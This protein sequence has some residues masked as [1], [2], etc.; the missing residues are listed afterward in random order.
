MWG[1]QVC[2]NGRCVG[3]AGVWD[4]RCVGIAGVCGMTGVWGWQVCGDGR[5]VEIA[6][7]WF[8]RIMGMGRILGVIFLSFPK[9]LYNRN[10]SVYVCAYT[11]G[12]I[13]MRL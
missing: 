8:V 6:G 2:G 4:G 7:C 10:N 9:L 1:W 3:M 11:Y 12:K 13:S 5:R